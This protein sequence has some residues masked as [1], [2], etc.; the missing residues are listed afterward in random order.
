MQ[1]DYVLDPKGEVILVV[2]K[3]NA[4]FAEWWPPVIVHNA[5]SRSATPVRRSTGWVDSTET[6]LEDSARNVYDS[7]TDGESPAPEP[8]TGT[9]NARIPLA[10]PCDGARASPGTMPNGSRSRNGCTNCRRR[11]RR[12]DE[13]KPACLWCT[14]TAAECIHPST[15]SASTHVKFIL[16]AAKNHYIVH[17]TMQAAKAAFLHMSLEDLIA[18]EGKFRGVDRPDKLPAAA[19]DELYWETQGSVDSHISRTFAHWHSTVASESMR[20]M[21]VTLIQYY[22]EV[23]SSSRV[24]IQTSNNPFSR[25]VPSGA[26]ESARTGPYY[27][28][29]SLAYKVRALKELQQRFN[30]ADNADENLLTCLLMTSLEIAEGSQPAWL[31]HLQGAYA[32]L[33]NFYTLLDPAILEFV[34]TYF[35]FRY[36]MMRTAGPKTMTELHEGGLSEFS[37][38]RVARPLVNAD[39]HS[40]FVDAPSLA[41]D[42]MIG[43]P[44]GIIHIIN[45][46][47][48]LSIAKGWETGDESHIR[49]YAQGQLFERRLMRLLLQNPKTPRLLF[50]NACPN[51]H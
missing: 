20:P 48:A 40:S 14:R 25:F 7:H 30:I 10:M 4:P 22:A 46:I 24:Y 17:F 34:L 1:P 44:M 45:G 13:E 31:K 15:H 3:P 49:P 18:C 51:M 37:E 5:S 36:I 26:R 42:E 41:T 47:T 33:D 32:L 39:T 16:S 43:C 11:K 38:E 23:I 2:H 28:S 21:E 9:D 8:A 6:E 12:C 50:S 19:E 29:M 35:R 27:H